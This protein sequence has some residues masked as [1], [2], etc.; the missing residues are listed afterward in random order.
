MALSPT[1]HFEVGQVRR[2]PVPPLDGELG[3]KLAVIA[4]EALRSAEKYAAGDEL[5]G[6]YEASWVDASRANDFRRALRESCESRV[7]FLSRRSFDQSQLTE[8][9]SE[10][11]GIEASDAEQILNTFGS[12]IRREERLRVRNL[13]DAPVIDKLSDAIEQTRRFVSG[14]VRAQLKQQPIIILSQC[15]QNVSTEIK[16]RFPSGDA[17]NDVATTLEIS[18]TDWLTEHFHVYHLVLHG[19]RPH[20][21][22][23][24][25]GNNRLA[26]FVDTRIASASHIRYALMDI[27]RPALQ[28]SRADLSAGL[29][30]PAARSAQETVSDAETMIRH[31]E[32][33]LSEWD[34][35]SDVRSRVALLEPLCSYVRRQ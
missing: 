34:V 28:R 20:I 11:L 14:Q 15:I 3:S 5:D 4:T 22:R 31:L 16:R 35:K 17:V 27:V 21:L 12:E 23:L 1:R 32:V 8:L 26:L 10:A 33:A 13:S 2:L 25:A 19:K 7:E 6:R 30:G 18:V 29:S 24:T 9:A